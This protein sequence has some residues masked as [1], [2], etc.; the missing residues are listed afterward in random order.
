MG[1]DG[2]PALSHIYIELLQYVIRLLDCR[3]SPNLCDIGFWITLP[4]AA[5]LGSCPVGFAPLGP[6]RSIVEFT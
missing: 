4:A 2:I 3:Q 5:G 6:V 1:H